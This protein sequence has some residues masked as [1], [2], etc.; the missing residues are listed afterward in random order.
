MKTPIDAPLSVYF[1]YAIVSAVYGR[2]RGNSGMYLLGDLFQIFEFVAFFF[3]ITVSVRSRR[4]LHTF[5][6]TGLIVLGVSSFSELWHWLS[7][8]VPFYIRV[9]GYNLP[10]ARGF[11]GALALPVLLALSVSARPRWVR[12]LRVAVA[13]G[14]VAVV[15]LSFTRTLWLGCATALAVFVLAVPYRAWI[16]LLLAWILAGIS[17]TG[18]AVAWTEPD[19]SLYAA[20]KSRLLY[21]LQ[22]VHGNTLQRLRLI[23]SQASSENLKR[24]PLLGIGLGGT[25]DAFG[26]LPGMFSPDYG[27]HGLSFVEKHYIHTMYASVALRLGLAGLGLYFWLMWSFCAAALRRYRSLRQQRN[28]LLLAGC[29]ASAVGAAVMAFTAPVAFSHPTGGV[30]ASI[31]ALGFVTGRTDDQLCAKR[32]L[33]R[34]LLGRS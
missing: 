28:R 12:A 25:Y 9:E 21:T 15:V 16:V 20:V 8:D 7:A 10:R 23:E 2:L 29:V 24:N 33:A 5:L 13:V 22:Q 32:R 18:L 4:V 26:A 11:V 34:W 6:S 30:L 31:L 27:V 19:V 1:L 3:L 17:V 14:T